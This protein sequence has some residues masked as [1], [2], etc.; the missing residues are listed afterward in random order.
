MNYTEADFEWID[1][2]KLHHFEQEHDNMTNAIL[3]IM[4]YTNYGEINH[5][6]TEFLDYDSLRVYLNGYI[7][8]VKYDVHT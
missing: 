4:D 5:N 7:K 3:G 1:P 8:L 6:Y 2:I